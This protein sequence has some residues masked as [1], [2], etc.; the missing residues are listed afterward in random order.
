MTRQVLG[1]LESALV[2]ASRWP[3]TDLIELASALE[4]MALDVDSAEE[5]WEELLGNLP[6]RAEEL[7]RLRATPPQQR[8]DARR[9]L[10]LHRVWRQV[11]LLAP[12][13]LPRV[14][15]LASAAGQGELPA[16]LRRHP[17]GADYLESALTLPPDEVKR[18]LRHQEPSGGG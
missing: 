17:D 14:R 10:L 5:R 16:Y 1:W 9:L 8:N 6:H 15:A 11:M 3:A 12:V 7:D 18:W 13:D 2:L 4:P